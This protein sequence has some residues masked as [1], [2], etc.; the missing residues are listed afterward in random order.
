MATE[1]L[2]DLAVIAMHGHEVLKSETQ[3][4]DLVSALEVFEQKF[5]VF[6]DPDTGSQEVVSDS[7]WLCLKDILKKAQIRA[8][9]LDCL[10]TNHKVSATLAIEPRST[11]PLPLDEAQPPNPHSSPHHGCTDKCVDPG[12]SLD[13]NILGKSRTKFDAEKVGMQ[14]S[15]EAAVHSGNKPLIPAPGIAKQH[16]PRK[17]SKA[18]IARQKD[19]DIMK[20]KYQLLSDPDT[21]S[22]NFKSFVRVI[23]KDTRDELFQMA[24]DFYQTKSRQVLLKL[25]VG[26][27]FNQC[28]NMILDTLLDYQAKALESNTIVTQSFYEQLAKMEEFATVLPEL[29][30]Q[31][32]HRQHMSTLQQMVHTMKKN[33]STVL[34]TFE[35]QKERHSKLLK[36]V[37][38]RPERVQSL[39]SLCS[40]EEERQKSWRVAVAD[41][42]CTFEACCTKHAQAYVHELAS[43]AEFLL[44]DCDK[45][46]IRN[47]F[48]AGL[49]T[50]AA[51]STTSLLQKHSATHGLDR[52]D[53]KVS[54]DTGGSVWPGL[55][56]ENYRNPSKPSNEMT[57][58]VVTTQTT[59]PHL[60][61]I[62]ARDRSYQEYIE[63]LER[64][65]EGC[66]EEDR[67]LLVDGQH[68]ATRWNDRA[69]L[70][71]NLHDREPAGPIVHPHST[72]DHPH[73]AQEP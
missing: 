57:P 35:K 63:E 3:S 2:S 10:Q 5:D 24:K 11:Q 49:Q 45:L 64:T 51:K 12:V 52:S 54:S 9:Y 61:I 58:S 60:R 40:E 1:K 22:N 55:P 39:A 73:S 36:P 8:Q 32:V 20:T 33:F 70:I 65:R 67:A 29:L 62:A 66:V 34:K 59:Q 25:K 4:R 53:L 19:H 17:P 26:S 18:M 28:A 44:H 23:L 41:H 37:L 7:L 6:T 21:E 47:D 48:Q 31:Q 69:R 13:Q 56:L 43:L 72:Q 16:Q 42:Y 68:W 30:I 27:T 50:K 14:T 71:K 15:G 38:G 46:I